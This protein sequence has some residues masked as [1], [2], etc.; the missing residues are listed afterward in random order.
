MGDA[1]LEMFPIELGSTNN[2]KLNRVL[3]YH[4]IVGNAKQGKNELLRMVPVVPTKGIS[5]Y[6]IDIGSNGIAV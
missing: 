1:G 4:F 3:Q 5:T 6:S 2:F